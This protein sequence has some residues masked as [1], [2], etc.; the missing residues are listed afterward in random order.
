MLQINLPSGAFLDQPT[1]LL[2][3]IDRLATILTGNADT[4]I[5]MV[6]NVGQCPGFI[7]AHLG[8]DGENPIVKVE[9]T[10]TGD[11]KSFEISAIIKG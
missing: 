3:Q 6:V 4:I 11:D 10:R 2:P 7:A 8:I 5:V 1:F 9:T